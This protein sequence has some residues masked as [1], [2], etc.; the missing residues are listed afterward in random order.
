MKCDVV[1]FRWHIRELDAFIY[2][3][4]VLD[5]LVGKDDEC[6]LLTVGTWYAMAGYAIAFPRNSRHLG[7]INDQ[8]LKYQSSGSIF[9][10][11]PSHVFFIKQSFLSCPFLSF[12]HWLTGHLE[13]WAKFWL[14]GACKPSKE[15]QANLVHLSYASLTLQQYMSAFLLLGGGI[16]LAAFLLSLEKGYF[17]CVRKPLSRGNRGCCTL[18]S[19]VSIC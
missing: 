18:V 6:R 1:F 17:A 15:A 12:L 19:L 3:S 9:F 11:L 16:I 13:Q 10:S 5:Y 4:S 2:D 7:M 8:L 14:A